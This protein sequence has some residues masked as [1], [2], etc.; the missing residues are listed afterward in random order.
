MTAAHRD[1][2]LEDLHK[3]GAL[4]ELLL[5]DTLRDLRAEVASLIHRNDELQVHNN[6][7]EAHIELAIAER[8]A[9]LVRVKEL[10]GEVA[11]MRRKGNVVATR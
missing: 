6:C 5:A 4:E 10:E 8:D 3:A 2:T 1:L 7:I 9:A 11:A